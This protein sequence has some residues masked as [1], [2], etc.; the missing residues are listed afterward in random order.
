LEIV[1]NNDAKITP[2][3]SGTVFSEFVAAKTETP[4]EPDGTADAL[5][6]R[7]STEALSSEGI[8]SFLKDI[9]LDEIPQEIAEEIKKDIAL[10]ALS[11]DGL[12]EKRKKVLD[13]LDTIM[14]TATGMFKKSDFHKMLGDDASKKAEDMI[15]QI[16]DELEKKKSK[17]NS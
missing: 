12:D 8:Q 1:E 11:E 9:S 7:D 5:P 17:P 15:N 4:V 6:P 2:A 14:K 16:Y 10:H 13:D 3:P